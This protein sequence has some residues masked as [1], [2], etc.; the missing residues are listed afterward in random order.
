MGGPSPKR[1]QTWFSSWSSCWCDRQG[2]SEAREKPIQLVDSFI[3]GSFVL[4]SIHFS[5]PTNAPHRSIASHSLST[6]RQ[7]NVNETLPRVE[8][9]GLSLTDEWARGRT[10]ERTSLGR[11]KYQQVLVKTHSRFPQETKPCLNRTGNVPSK[12]ES[13]WSGLCPPQAKAVGLSTTSW[14]P[15]GFLRGGV[16]A[17]RASIAG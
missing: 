9:D 13:N 5:F 16:G 17:C 1:D 15:L 6:D 12:P 3:R 11:S 4:G 14:L 2:M 10:A 7:A 8:G